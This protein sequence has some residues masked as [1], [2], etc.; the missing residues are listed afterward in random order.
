M[1]SINQSRLPLLFRI[2]KLH[3]LA[4]QAIKKIQKQGSGVQEHRNSRG[5]TVGEN[6]NNGQK[7]HIKRR[8]EGALENQ[9]HSELIKSRKCRTSSQSLTNQKTQF[10]AAMVGSIFSLFYSFER[11]SGMDI[12]IYY[13][14][15]KWLHVLSLSAKPKAPEIITAISNSIM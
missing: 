15:E 4:Q 11:S 12:N 2:A 13:Y 8:F 6:V 9:T 1:N 7:K 14:H 3:E 10:L 5:L